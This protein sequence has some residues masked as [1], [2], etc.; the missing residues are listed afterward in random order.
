MEKLYAN[1]KKITDKNG[2]IEFEGEIPV[3]ILDEYLKEELAHAA[4]D[5]EWPGFRKGKVPESIVRE[6]VSEMALLDSAADEILHD[7][8]PEIAADE[9][10]SVL[11][12]PQLTVT[13]IA[14]KNPLGFTV[15]FALSPAVELPDYKKIGRAI[16]AREEKI[17]V[18]EK[19]IDEAIERI[20][21]MIP[22]AGPSKGIATPP[23]EL[24]D[25]FVKQL[26]PFE[27]VAGF[28]AELKRQITEEKKLEHTEAKRDEMVREIAKQSKV[29]VPQMLIEQEV[30]DWKGNRDA[31]LEKAG[32]TLEKYLEQVKKTEADLEK[33]ARRQIEEQMRT[34]FVL[35]EIRKA[36]DIKADEKEIRENVAHLKRRYPEQDE[37]SLAGP[38]EAIA[39]QGKLF[40]VLEGGK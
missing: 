10:L 38:A 8:I 7:V 16:A 6:H 2:E 21:R 36:E 30:E 4:Q 40:K 19:E 9:K 25:D 11:G 32:L 35:R 20:K 17:E 23:P 14:P 37:T 5:F 1:L 24:T 26:G 12:K 39:I 27:D 3:A 33:D 22:I 13:K 15:K 28:R 29:K 31:E 34:S 18:D